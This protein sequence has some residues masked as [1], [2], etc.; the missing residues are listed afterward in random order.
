[1]QVSS[2]LSL[3]CLFAQL[4]ITPRRRCQAEKGCCEALK[5]MFVLHSWNPS[6]LMFFFPPFQ[7][8]IR[9][10]WPCYTGAA[11]VVAHDQG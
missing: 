5:R 1:M 7:V 4:Q 11:E 8:L 6:Q 2:S 9:V 3:C 10:R